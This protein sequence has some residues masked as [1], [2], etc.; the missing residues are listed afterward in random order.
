MFEYIWVCVKCMCNE[1]KHVRVDVE[2]KH[3]CVD[4]E[5]KH[6]LMWVENS[7][8]HRQLGGCSAPHN[9]CS[10]LHN[11]HAAHCKAHAGEWVFAAHHTS[12]RRLDWV[13]AEHMYEGAEH[14][15]TCT[16]VQSTSTHTHGCRAQACTHMG[17]EHK[18]A[19]AWV[20]SISMHVGPEHKDARIRG[21]KAQART[22]G[23]QAYV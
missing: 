14:K 8:L 4:A 21:C 9:T 11:K 7:A 1:Y 10:A 13:S 16:W 22:C 20:Q 2:Y 12:R 17:A 18:H 6:V 23:I 3:V 19:H 5:Y 15:R